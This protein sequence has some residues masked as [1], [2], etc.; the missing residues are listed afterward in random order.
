MK[1]RTNYSGVIFNM[2]GMT[3]PDKIVRSANAERSLDPQDLLAIAVKRVS[4]AETSTFLSNNT[5]FLDPALSQR[6]LRAWV[7]I[8]C[9]VMKGGQIVSDRNLQRDAQRI[10][11]RQNTVLQL[12]SR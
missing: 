7:E 2:R 12:Q 11:Q 1:L 4:L 8:V 10:V 9:N 3:Q 5:P 6:Q